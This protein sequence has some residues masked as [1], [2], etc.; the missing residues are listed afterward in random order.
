MKIFLIERT[1]KVNCDEYNGHVVQARDENRAYAVIETVDIGAYGSTACVK[2]NT[3]CTIVGTGKGREEK[4]I[5]S[6]Y[7]AG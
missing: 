3:T 4:V 5:L 2:E 7:N 6:S 1:D